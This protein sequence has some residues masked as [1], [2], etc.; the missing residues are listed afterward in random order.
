MNLKK[1]LEPYGHL[2]YLRPKLI[3]FGFIFLLLIYI[4]AEASVISHGIPSPATPY[5]YDMDEWHHFMGMTGLFKHFSNNLPGGMEGTSFFLISSGVYM[6]FFVLLHIIH[7]SLI[8][9]HFTP[10]GL[11][12]LNHAFI[13]LR[14]VTVIFGCL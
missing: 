1:K 10:L 11:T 9:Q 13:V 2:K 6:A 12:E 3:P 14:T 4:A 5:P 8:S 7:P